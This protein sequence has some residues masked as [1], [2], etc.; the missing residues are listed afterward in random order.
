MTEENIENNEFVKKTETVE[1]TESSETVEPDEATEKNETQPPK[2]AA[3]AIAKFKEVLPTNWTL[4][5]IFVAIIGYALLQ[6][7][8]GGFDSDMWWILETG[9]EILENGIPY[10]NPWSIYDDMKIVVQ[11]PLAS[12]ILYSVYNAAG[13]MGI[14]IYTFALFVLMALV[15][16]ATCRIVSSKKWGSGE[17]FGFIIAIAIFSLGSYLS[18]RPHVYSM[19]FFSLTLLVLELYRRKNNFLVLIALPVITCLHVNFHAA[20]APF[21]L[22]IILLYLIPDVPGIFARIKKPIPAGFY[23]STYDRL[24]L[25]IAF[26]C[27]AGGL[28]L[29]PYGFNGAMYVLLSYGSAGYGNYI[30]EMQ[31]TRFWNDYGI[32]T[33]AM[34]ALGCVALGKRGL[35]NID[36]PLTV[37]FIGS[38]PLSMMHVRNVW[39][40]SLFAIY[41]FVGTFRDVQLNC[42]KI[43][44]VVSNKAFHITFIVVL[45][46]ISTGWYATQKWPE[47][48]ENAEDD[49]ATIPSAA[50]DYLD[51][52]TAEHKV[53]KS[54]LNIYNTFNCGGYMEWR[55]YKVYMDQRPELWEPTITGKTNHYYQDYVDSQDSSQTSQQILD[56]NNFDFLIVPLNSKM[57]S[58][59]TLDQAYKKVVSGQG[60]TLYAKSSLGAKPEE[61]KQELPEINNVDDLKN[62]TAPGGGIKLTNNS[63]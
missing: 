18:E 5:T 39:L 38:I 54:S 17:V 50:M 30:N 9:R 28:L 3:S 8:T 24:P 37:L 23:L 36:F 7:N 1:T 25:F 57:D 41:L 20:M 62:A 53:S 56:S 60:Y 58:K 43:Q 14:K 15:L 46:V 59:I 40:V 13:F 51:E 6:A 19:I 22:V 42:K 55:G 52:Y 32:P 27:A 35:K 12:V 11:Q 29:N 49:S 44:R 45:A 48:V 2:P 26:V 10:T 33:M 16:F 61:E 4:L 63:N 21:D 34:I 47:F 31:S